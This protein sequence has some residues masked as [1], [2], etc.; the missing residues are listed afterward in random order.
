MRRRT[1]PLL[2]A[3]AVIACSALLPAGQ[4][5]GGDA[6]ASVSRSAD[7]SSAHCAPS[8]TAR[9]PIGAKVRE[10]RLLTEARQA[11]MELD[12]Q[13]RQRDMRHQ[14]VQVRA[15]AI[16][17]D[18]YVHVVHDGGTG[19]V[20]K[21]QITEQIKV[22]NDSYSGKTG[23]DATSV[24]FSLAGTDRTDNSTWATAKPNSSAERSMKKKLRRGGAS[25]LNLYIAEPAGG[26]LGW[27]TMPSWYEKHKKSDG[28]VVLYSTLPGG[29]TADYDEGDTATHEIGHWL[30]L[31][32]TF[33]G[34][35]TGE[36]D[37]VADT[38]AEA[39]AAYECPTSRDS[40]ATAPGNDSVHNFMNYVYDQCMNEFT[41]G[42][43]DRIGKQWQ[44]YRAS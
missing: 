25:D 7:G 34:G 29:S 26:L 17:V 22:L 33:E 10:P 38:P 13:R 1:F 44:A 15:A 31:Y 24:S 2:A 11:A 43:A 27:A 5:D 28:V 9:V 19:N 16:K 12:F 8:G 4:R 30:G 40:C 23:G 36:G 14:G 41:A 21:A 20:G 18:V 39:T 42:Q 37:H 6:A 3:A 32:H 35:C